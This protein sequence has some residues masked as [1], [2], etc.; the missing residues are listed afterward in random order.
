MFLVMA[1]YYLANMTNTI[2]SQSMQTVLIV[3]G[4]P[5]GLYYAI[6]HKKN[7]PDDKVIVLDRNANDSTF[8]WGVV[9][10]DA[11]VENIKDADHISAAN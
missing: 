10:S 3:G 1:H 6:L 2:R 11:T 9:F 4:G 5:T 8:G 7:Y